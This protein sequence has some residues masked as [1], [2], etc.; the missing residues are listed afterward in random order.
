M[1]NLLCF[2]CHDLS[3]AL[4]Y[5]GWTSNLKEFHRYFLFIGAGV[6]DVSWLKDTDQYYHI[7]N[8]ESIEN[9]KDIANRFF[10][11]LTG[12]QYINLLI[13][14]DVQTLDSQQ[15]NKILAEMNS[16]LEPV[17]LHN[18]FGISKEYLVF[19]G[20]L[21]KEEKAIIKSELTNDQKNLE[22]IN[23][24]QGKEVGLETFLNMV[25]DNILVGKIETHNIEKLGKLNNV[26]KILMS[27]SGRSNEPETIIFS[28]EDYIEASIR[29][30]YK[31]KIAVVLSSDKSSL[32]I[33]KTR[34]NQ[35]YCSDGFNAIIEYI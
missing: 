19:H 35:V 6:G 9:W 1:K 26:A 11:L 5:A 20:E 29:E 16:K 30:N 22:T 31:G 18:I 4:K 14:Y 3:D 32:D 12:L 7:K 24:T 21:I 8:L 23:A 25:L 28:R 13:C 27:Y 10:F 17:H 33:N 34:I 2:I 15:L